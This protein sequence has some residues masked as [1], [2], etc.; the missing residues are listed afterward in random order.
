MTVI[1]LTIVLDQGQL[2]KNVV[3][4]DLPITFSVSYRVTLTGQTADKRL[5]FIG[6]DTPTCNMVMWSSLLGLM[7]VQSS[8]EIWKSPPKEEMPVC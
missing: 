5:R 1:D 7:A 3:K 2:T 6:S 4:S 8:A